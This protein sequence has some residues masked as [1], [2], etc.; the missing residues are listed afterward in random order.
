M[1]DGDNIDSDKELQDKELVEKIKRGDEKSFHL[2]TTRYYKMV[3]YLCL[4]VFHSKEKAEDATQEVFI[5]VWKNINTCTDGTYFISWLT[6]I[7]KN[8]CIDILRKEKKLRERETSIEE[9][10]NKDKIIKNTIEHQSISEHLKFEYL[11]TLIEQLPES[12]RIV[13]QKRLEGC[14]VQEIA[15]ELNCPIGTVL[16]RFSLAKKKIYEQMKRANIKFNDF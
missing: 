7:A 9:I 5:K 16:S 14:S 12:Q 2:L 10:E 13:F 3:Y 6:T 8:H 15:D 11:S 1:I 4:K